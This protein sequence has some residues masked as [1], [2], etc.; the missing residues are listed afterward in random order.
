VRSR[1]LRSTG[2]YEAKSFSLRARHQTAWA[3]DAAR[4]LSLCSSTGP[5][6]ALFQSR[7]VTRTRLARTTPRDATVR[8]GELVEQAADLWGGE[9][10]VGDAIERCE[11][12]GTAGGTTRRHHRLLNPSRGSTRPGRGR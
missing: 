7:R 4:V 9:F 3:S 1:F 5:L 10:L 12:L 11:L 2:R 6:R 8:I